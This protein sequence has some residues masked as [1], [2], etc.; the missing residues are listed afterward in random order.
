[1]LTSRPTNINFFSRKGNARRVRCQHAQFRR[2]ACEATQGKAWQPKIGQPN[3]EKEGGERNGRRRIAGSVFFLV[4][5][6]DPLKL[7]HKN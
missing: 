2:V 1:M 7:S 3:R 4:V 6:F 5:N